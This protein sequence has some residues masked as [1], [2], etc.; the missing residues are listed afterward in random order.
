M[1]R[2][3]RRSS[4]SRA[5]RTSLWVTAASPRSSLSESASF[6]AS[7]NVRAASPRDGSPLADEPRL[8]RRAQQSEAALLTAGSPAFAWRMTRQRTSVASEGVA[9]RWKWRLVLVRRSAGRVLRGSASAYVRRLGLSRRRG[10]D[11]QLRSSL[12]PYRA[13]RA[14]AGLERRRPPQPRIADAQGRP[15]DGLLYGARPQD[16]ALSALEQ[17]GG[18]QELGA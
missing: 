6:T 13:L 17:R 10:H 11:R 18:R 8:R 2:P 4:S 5:S 12:A 3:V 1:S 15:A 14:Q 9:H 7:P 16:D